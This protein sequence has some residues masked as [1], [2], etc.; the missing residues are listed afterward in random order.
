MYFW[1]ENMVNINSRYCFVSKDPIVILYIR[2]PVLPEVVQLLTS[3]MILCTTKCGRRL[4]RVQFSTW[5]ELSAIE[6]S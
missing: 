3:T 1:K 5:R 4:E 6:F 2:M